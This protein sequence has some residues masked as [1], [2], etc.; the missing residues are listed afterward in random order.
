MSN[1]TLKQRLDGLLFAMLGDAELVERW[2][3]RPN[4][5]FNGA[6]PIDVLVVQPER[7]RDHVL[8]S[9]GLRGRCD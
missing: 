2:W 4:Q 6:L 3:H 1:I 9:C 7:V 8:E 5:N